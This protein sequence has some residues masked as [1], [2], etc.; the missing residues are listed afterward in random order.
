MN[1]LLQALGTTAPAPLADRLG[2]LAEGA[3]VAAIN[4]GLALAV[5]LIGWLAARICFSVVQW[6][7]RML[8]FNHAVRR[9]LGQ[10]SLIVGLEASATAG[11][12]VYWGV[13]LLSGL[14]ALD[15]LGIHAFNAVGQR[16]TEVL[17]RIVVASFV[18]L[19]GMVAAVLV[20]AILRSALR[21]MG[22]MR[23]ALAG[24]LGSIGVLVFA[25]L[26]ALEQ[27]GLA[28]QLVVGVGL[29]LV[30]ALGLAVGL[31]FGLGCRDLARDLLIEYLRSLDEQTTSL[32]SRTG[33]GRD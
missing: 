1:I 12:I 27:P 11:W 28:A 33:S 22:W 26:L 8:R 30:A 14:V 16:L 15:L 31:A 9:M 5:L 7:L 32:R 3:R 6:L 25:G 23:P 29:I 19:G 10:P 4:I 21:G 20:G 2:W 13:M 24:Q 17:P 18:A